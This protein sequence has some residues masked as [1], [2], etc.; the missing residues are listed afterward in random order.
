VDDYTWFVCDND[1]PWVQDGTREMAG[2]A[3]DQFQQQQVRD[4]EQRAVP[5]VTLTGPVE[6]RVQQV[7]DALGVP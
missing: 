7:K 1:F 2:E 3:A 6:Q 4:L 5:F